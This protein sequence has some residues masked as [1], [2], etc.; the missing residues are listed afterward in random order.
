MEKNQAKQFRSEMESRYAECN[1]EKVSFNELVCFKDGKNEFVVGQFSKNEHFDEELGAYGEI[2][3]EAFDSSK[4]GVFAVLL[5]NGKLAG[6]PVTIFA[7]SESE[8]L[9]RWY[10][11]DGPEERAYGGT[12][13][14]TVHIGKKPYYLS[15]SRRNSDD[16]FCFV[17]SEKGFCADISSEKLTT[18][19]EHGMR[20]DMRDV[21]KRIDRSKKDDSS[22]ENRISLRNYF[23][24]SVKQQKNL[25]NLF[26]KFV[27]PVISV[28]QIVKEEKK[29]MKR[30]ERFGKLRK[31]VEK[32]RAKFA[33]AQKRMVEKEAKEKQIASQKQINK[34][35]EK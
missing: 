13:D 29:A 10:D 11:R 23:K 2:R 24:R 7:K 1:D 31:L 8:H 17:R 18:M 35:F 21:L 19:L 4:R 27:G 3:R 34:F 16:G 12:T 26:K 30:A 28:D 20:E 32:K 22:L 5:E 6:E 9:C 25:E 14:L 15:S 33:E